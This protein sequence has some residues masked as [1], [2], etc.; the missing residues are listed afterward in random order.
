LSPAVS[1]T[2]ITAM[3]STIAGTAD[4]TLASAKFNYPK[5]MAFDSSGDMYVADTGNQTIR[6]ITF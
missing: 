5:G 6:K 4:G 2:S 1:G 3:V